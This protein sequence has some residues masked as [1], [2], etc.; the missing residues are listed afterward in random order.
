MCQG[1][2]P[3]SFHEV[4]YSWPRH[5]QIR[6]QGSQICGE[7]THPLDRWFIVDIWFLQFQW[8]G[9][10]LRLHYGIVSENGLNLVKAKTFW[11]NMKVGSI[12]NLA[13]FLAVILVFARPIAATV[14]LTAPACSRWY[15]CRSGVWCPEYEE[16]SMVKGA[17]CCPAVILRDTFFVC[18]IAWGLLRMRRMPRSLNFIFRTHWYRH[19]TLRNGMLEI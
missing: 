4:L 5:H 1:P 15:R 9:Q 11:L 13:C 10:E 3:F 7:T 8:W 18:L 19:Q 2:G 6:V 14:L 17:W 16:V 12:W